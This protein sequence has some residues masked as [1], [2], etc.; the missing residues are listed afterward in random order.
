[1][2]A[3]NILVVCKTDRIQKDAMCPQV[4]HIIMCEDTK[5]TRINLSILNAEENVVCFSKIYFD[6]EQKKI[7]C[8]YG[9]NIYE[10]GLSDTGQKSVIY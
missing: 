5:F 3:D 8:S 7:P 2:C 10:C 6:T 1:M 9:M 4:N